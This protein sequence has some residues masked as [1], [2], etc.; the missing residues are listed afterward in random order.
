M[1]AHLGKNAWRC[2]PA[3]ARFRRLTHEQN[4]NIWNRLVATMLRPNLAGRPNE[5]EMFDDAECCR[6][7]FFDARD[8]RVGAYRQPAH[9]GLAD[10]DA[11]APQQPPVPPA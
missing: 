10:G 6:Y 2:N 7:S 11:G 4:G 3:N 9:P 1:A 5:P 8:G